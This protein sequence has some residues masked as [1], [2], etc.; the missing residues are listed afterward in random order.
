MTQIYQEE[1]YT[2]RFDFGV[3]KK[4]ARFAQAYKA[5]FL[6]LAG[7]MIVVGVIDAVFPLMSKYAVDHFII[8]GTLDGLGKFGLGFLALI[9]FQAANVWL[10]IAIAGKINMGMSYDIRRAGF[11]RLQE[12]SF[13]YYDTTPLG[14]MMARMTSDTRRLADVLAWGAVDF[15]W[16]ATTMLAIMA[17]ML[18]LNW[19]LAL[20]T[21]TVAPPLVVFSLYFQQKI[22]HAHRQVHKVNSHITAGFN[23]GISGAKTTKTL[24]REQENLR[25]FQQETGQMYRS[26]VQAA[27][28]ASLYLPSVLLLGSIGSGLAL[29]FGGQRV[30]CRR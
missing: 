5:H 24:V 25:E 1:D 3:W 23:E 6:G 20:I 30:M 21:L 27:I 10:L 8:P 18:W 16:G 13:A 28:F 29:W 17:A 9:V 2:K 12:L 19:K 11:Q 4:L 22:L 26:A 7:V 15:I 14:W